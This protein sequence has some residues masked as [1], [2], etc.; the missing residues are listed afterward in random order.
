M[1]TVPF[2]SSRS[3]CSPG[4][5]TTWATNSMASCGWG[6]RRDRRH[7]LPGPVRAAGRRR[8]AV[9]HGP[10]RRP[11]PGRGRAARAVPEDV[12]RAGRV[13]PRSC[14]V[15]VGRHPRVLLGCRRT[16][17]RRR[18]V[19]GRVVDALR[20]DG[21]DGRAAARRVLPRWSHPRCGEGRRGRDGAHGPGPAA[22]GVPGHGDDR[23]GHRSPAAGHGRDERGGVR[24]VP[25]RHRSDG[26]DD[27]PACGDAGHRPVRPTAR[28]DLRL[29]RP[30]RR[31]GGAAR[32]VRPGRADLHRGG[33]EPV[34]LRRRG[35]GVDAGRGP[36][37]GRDRLRARSCRSS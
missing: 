31:D 1:P 9:R 17:R 13:G 30:A 36:Q 10:R 35:V 5:P 23:R 15:A 14:G 8:R 21:G 27:R 28:A 19:L 24:R 3:A 22:R 12:Q 37:D 11:R 2:P 34:H 25:G 7:R 33:P 29:G 6:R 16:R 20:V 4:P 32:A 18:L 26:R